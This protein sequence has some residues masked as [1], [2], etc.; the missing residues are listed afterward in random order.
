MGLFAVESKVHR[1]N[2]DKLTRDQ[3]FDIWMEYIHW[4]GDAT[5]IRAYIDKSANT[6]DWLMGMG[7]KLEYPDQPEGQYNTGLLVVA[8][9][10]HTGAN[11]TATMMKRLTERAQKLGVRIFLRTPANKILKENKEK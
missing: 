6:I 4:N 5:L 1:D 9:D 2:N 3:A 11:A 7:L 10:G 8:D